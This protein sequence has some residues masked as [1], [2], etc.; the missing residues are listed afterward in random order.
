MEIKK[1]LKMDIEEF[2]EIMTEEEYEKMQELKIK[3]I[4]QLLDLMQEGAR[5]LLE[6]DE[7]A[8]KFVSISEYLEYLEENKIDTEELEWCL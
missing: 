1:L 4:W 7:N 2:T 3:Y 5:L 6:T 8:T